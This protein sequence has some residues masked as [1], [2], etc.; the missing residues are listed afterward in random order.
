MSYRNIATPILFIFLSIP[1]LV[2]GQE[3][4]SVITSVISGYIE[5]F[6]VNDYDKMESNLHADLSKRGI[7]PDGALSDNYS[8]EDLRKLM[9]NK[10][11]LPLSKQL[12]TIRDIKIHNRVATAVLETGYPN[13]RWK[14]YIHLIMLDGKWIIADVMWCFDK[15]E[16]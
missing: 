13:T 4:E 12:N 16:D 9:E 11:P 8:K 7:N 5:N 10:P 14:E 15:I 6:F 3:E 1:Q 2:Q